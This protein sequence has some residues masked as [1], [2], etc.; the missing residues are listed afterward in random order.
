MP[1]C[2]EKSFTCCVSSPLVVFP[3]F[4]KVLSV[5]RCR[6]LRDPWYTV[7]FLTNTI[8]LVLMVVLLIGTYTD[9]SG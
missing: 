2:K 5:M 6:Y 7:N 8:L 1:R 9:V 3:P 4:Q